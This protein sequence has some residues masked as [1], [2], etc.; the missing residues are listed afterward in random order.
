ML[1][2]ERRR[3]ILKIIN[4]RKS[5][6]VKELCAILYASPATVRS[7]LCELENDGLITRSFGGAVLNEQFPNQVPASVRSVDKIDVKKLLAAKAASLIKSGETVFID[8]STTTYYLAPHLKSIPDITVITN[9]PKLNIALAENHVR[10][11]CTGG[12]MLNESMVLTGISA[13]RFVRGIRAHKFFFSSRG[14]DDSCISDSCAYQCGVKQAM[15][16]CSEQSYYLCDN[17]KFGRTYPHVI[18][19]LSRVSRIITEE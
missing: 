7:D 3:D 10:S 8:G 19:D 6:T 1:Q 9:N 13:E 5:I 16:E 11:F 4:E 17:G 2:I 15:I 12:E 14:I 18:C